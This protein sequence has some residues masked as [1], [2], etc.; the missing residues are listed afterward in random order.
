[1][2]A[3]ESEREIDSKQKECATKK[4]KF[5]EDENIEKCFKHSW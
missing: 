5:E 3:Y 4:K 2:N 1:M